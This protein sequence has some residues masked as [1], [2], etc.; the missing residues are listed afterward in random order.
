MKNCLAILLFVL[1]GC[2]AGPNFE[3][4][5]APQSHEYTQPGATASTGTAASQRIV[6]G[7]DVAAD[8]WT[9]FWL[10]RLE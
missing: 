5:S 7:G 1:G 8:W 6:L 4:P 10:R 2:A 9:L 3:R